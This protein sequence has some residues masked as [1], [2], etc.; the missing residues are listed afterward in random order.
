MDN[1]IF[2]RGQKNVFKNTEDS[3]KYEGAIPEMD[4]FMKFRGGIW[5]KDD[6]TP[7]LPWIEK[8]RKELKDKIT[9]VKEFY[10]IEIG[11]I[12]KIK[13]RKKWAVPG[14]DGIH[15]FRP[16]QKTLKKEFEQMRDINRLIPIWWLLGGTVPIPKSKDLSDEKNYHPI[17]C[18]STSYKPFTGLVGTFMRNHKTENNIQDE[19]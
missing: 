19:G 8:M 14:V 1:N 13:K 2:E 5:E 11:L 7:N 3:T 18:L 16:A 9:I 4:K 6:G 12:S 15:M 10:I 17:T